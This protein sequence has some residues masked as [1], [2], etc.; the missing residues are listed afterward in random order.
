MEYVIG[1]DLGGTQLRAGLADELG[2]IYTEVRVPTEA[3]HGPASVIDRI[4]ACIAQVRTALPSDATLCGV[5]I[6]SPG[7]LDPYTGIVFTTPNMPGWDHVPL[8]DLLIERTG[9]PVVL[10][11]DANVA[12]LG[13]WRFG[14]GQG[15]RHLVYLTIST[16]IGGG[17]ISDGRLLL[18]RMGAAG[19]LGHMILD[20]ANRTVWEDMASGTALAAYAAQAMPGVPE[21][22]LHE[23]ATPLTVSA[24]DVARAAARGDALARALMQREAELLGL[25]LVSTLHLFSPEIILVGGSVVT[26]NSYLLE[27]ARQVVQERVLADVY[28][29]VPIQVATLGEQVGV[30]GAV[31]LVLYQRD[32]GQ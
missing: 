30:L 4:V 32:A 23:F 7:P 6:G 9:L 27:G 28:R 10:G 8:R 5:G 24:A 29:Q 1:V 20:A 19:E 22:L 13:E 26:Q 16:G 17:V 11:N 3:Q 2:R 15:C 14:G 31:A 21:S 12:A 25:G 18:G